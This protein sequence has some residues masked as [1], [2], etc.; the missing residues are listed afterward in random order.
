MQEK[1]CFLLSDFLHGDQYARY[2]SIELL[3]SW[4]FGIGG[5][6]WPVAHCLCDYF[7]SHFT[8]EFFANKRIMELGSGT[9]IVGIVCSL[10]DV[11]NTSLVFISDIVCFL[12]FITGI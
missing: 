7:Q 12:Y 4:K 9:G 8:P 11:S 5:T 1:V 6:C 2:A 3:S 10:L